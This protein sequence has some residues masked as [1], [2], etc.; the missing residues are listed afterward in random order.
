[1]FLVGKIV[2]TFGNK[3]DVKVKAFISPPDYLLEFDSIF[4]ESTS[5]NKQEF[6]VLRAK[7][8]KNICIFTLEGVDTMDVAEDLSGLSIYVPN[9]EFKELQDNEYYYHE[10]EGLNVY[11]ANGEQIGK[12]DHILKSGN[13]ILVIKDK[14]GKEV[15]VPFVDE[16]VPEVNLNEKTITV[17]AIEGLIEGV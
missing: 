3:G 4:V 13:D 8:H 6:K 12:V 10:L 7:N 15:M 9:I 17:N 2:G 5:G 14:D 16:L 11:A 1:M